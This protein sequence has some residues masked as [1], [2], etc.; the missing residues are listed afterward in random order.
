MRSQN[1]TPRV[2]RKQPMNKK[3]NDDAK[4]LAYNELK[5]T[6]SIIINHLLG[7]SVSSTSASA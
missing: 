2:E 4:M 3:I 5:K 6:R 7:N 1:V